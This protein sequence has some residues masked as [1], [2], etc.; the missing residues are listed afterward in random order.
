MDLALMAKMTPQP[1]S[2]AI[3]PFARCAPTW[4]LL[5][6]S[7]GAI[8][9]L[10]AVTGADAAH[11]QSKPVRARPP[12]LDESRFEAIFFDDV[13]SQ[14]Q[15]D[16]PSERA[17]RNS[18]P[19]MSNDPGGEPVAG[20]NDDPMGWKTLISAASLED[21]IKETKLRLDREI[22]TPAAFNGGGFKVAR[23]EFSLLALLFAII[24]NYPGDVRWKSDAAAARERLAR[25]AAN[26]KVGSIQ[27]YQEAKQRLLDLDD[28]VRG[29]SL[30][31]TTDSEIDWSN[32]IDRVP[33]MQLLEW[34]Y[35]QEL[36][37]Q[38]ASE[39]EF[40]ANQDAIRRYAELIAVL[41]KTMLFEEMPDATDEDYQQFTQEMIQQALQVRL[42]VETDNPD[43]ARRAAGAI[44]QS[45]STCHENFR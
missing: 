4:S 24:E 37:K 5:T 18:Q 25:A 2:S 31:A 15:G 22:T 26:T 30:N 44:G 3:R 23:R 41:G 45:C 42:A 21:L 8:A 27:T 11:A 9:M 13:K 17:E 19:T 1:T 28:L 32:L 36:S 29:S 12:K 40:E 35:Q 10:T 33:I 7:I 34:A 14:L 6:I 43:L 20:Q 39:S 16:L 38:V